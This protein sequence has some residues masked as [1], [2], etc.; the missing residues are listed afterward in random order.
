VTRTSRES[1]TRDGEEGW[2]RQSFE[3]GGP[4]GRRSYDVSVKGGDERDGNGSSAVNH[5]YRERSISI[6]KGGIPVEGLTFD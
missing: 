3:K 1:D 2:R 4:D 6:E 5:R